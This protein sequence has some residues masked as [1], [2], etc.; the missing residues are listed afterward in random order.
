MVASPRTDSAAARQ[1]ATRVR[2]ERKAALDEHRSRMF[3]EIQQHTNDRDW[4]KAL[5]SAHR[6]ITTFPE[7]MEA[8]ALKVQLPT[9]EEN[10]RIQQRQQ[11]EREYEALV[12]ER[13]FA[14]AIELGQQIISDYP[15][16]SSASILRHQLPKLR[17]R[18]ATE[19]LP[20]R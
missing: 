18:M 7:G 2:R 14:D 19:T 6:F 11:M 4:S 8:E 10:A 16:S 9:L 12:R 20:G 17:E 1:L 13:R 3:A 5:D 15:D